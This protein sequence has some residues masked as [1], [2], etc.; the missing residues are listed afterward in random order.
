MGIIEA[1]QTGPVR[2]MQRER[3]CQ[4]MRPLGRNVNAADLE[5]DPMA[6][7]KVMDAAIEGEQELQ[8]VVR[9]ARRH[10]SER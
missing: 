10:R 9:C 4:A 8:A 7:L 6:L 5:F 2:R 1:D 3:I